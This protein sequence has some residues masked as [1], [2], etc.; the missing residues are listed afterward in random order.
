M[1]P[2]QSYLLLLSTGASMTRSNPMRCVRCFLQGIGVSVT[3]ARRLTFDAQYTESISYPTPNTFYSTDGSPPFN[4][5]DRTP[6]NTNGLYMEWL[7]FMLSKVIISQTISTSYVGDEQTVLWDYAHPYV[8]LFA[9]LGAR[10]S[11]IL[12]SSGDEGVC[13][14][15]CPSDNSANSVKSILQFPAWCVYACLHNECTRFT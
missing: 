7:D 8:K 6:G 3:S 9:R 13:S 15:S 10:G 1:P 14:R 4:P 5:D 12:F 11:S 2:L